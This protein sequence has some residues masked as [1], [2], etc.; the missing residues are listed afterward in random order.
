MYRRCSLFCGNDIQE[1]ARPSLRGVLA[2]WQSSMTLYALHL[3]MFEST[4]VNRYIVPYHFFT[5][6]C[7]ECGTT[8]GG[9]VGT[10]TSTLSAGCC[11]SLSLFIFRLVAHE[12][13][14]A[15]DSSI[16][17]T[18]NI[19]RAICL[20]LCIFPRFVYDYRRMR[21]FVIR[22]FIYHRT[23]CS[24]SSVAGIPLHE[25]FVIILPTISI[26]KFVNTV[27]D[28]LA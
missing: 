1:Y 3:P 22:R 5:P 14:Y 8:T 2:T 10:K 6:S 17:A 15:S 24:S 9:C 11:F 28:S 20:L 18:A 12:Q 16:T 23:R 26:S 19:S 7:H 27:V 4:S 13:K 25:I 21:W